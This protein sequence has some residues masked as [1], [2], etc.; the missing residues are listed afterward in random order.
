[1]ST[2]PAY[3]AKA[4]SQGVLK[5]GFV[6]TGNISWTHLR[7]LEKRKIGRAHV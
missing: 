5:V 2:Q 7:I 6:G 1:M 3:G 4:K